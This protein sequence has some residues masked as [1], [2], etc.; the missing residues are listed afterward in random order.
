M[1]AKSTLIITAL[2]VELQIQILSNLD[3][4]S[5]ISAA[6]VCNLW[7]SIISTTKQ[8]QRNRYMTYEEHG[9]TG[10]HRILADVNGRLVCIV[11]DGKV[12]A[13]KKRIGIDKDSGK[14]LWEDITGSWTLDEPVISP[15]EFAENK[16]IRTMEGDDWSSPE[17]PPG[18]CSCESEPDA[19]VT[20]YDEFEVSM[21]ATFINICAY[22][23]ERWSSFRFWTSKRGIMLSDPKRS[24]RSLFEWLVEA[25]ESREVSKDIRPGMRG[26]KWNLEFEDPGGEDVVIRLLFGPSVFSPGRGAS[27]GFFLTACM[28]KEDDE[29]CWLRTRVERDT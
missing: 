7:Q 19:D 15:F 28:E 22:R 5:Q 4:E 18:K 12:A 16:H 21:R 1:P 9:L 14:V 3:L 23:K 24:I 6:S 13:F 25:V 26:A 29:V 11:K 17:C 27:W 8:P 2:P 10:L 20:D